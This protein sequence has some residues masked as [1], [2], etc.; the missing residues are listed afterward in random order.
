MADGISSTMAM[1]DEAMGAANRAEP[2]IRGL[3]TK[4]GYGWMVYLGSKSY[5]AC[6]GIIVE[7]WQAHFAHF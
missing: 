5:E 2:I 3:D 1:M 6:L 7:H 4:E